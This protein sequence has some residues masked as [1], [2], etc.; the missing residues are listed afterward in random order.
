MAKGDK[1]ELVKERA[2]RERKPARLF[3]QTPE[4]NNR[5]QSSNRRATTGADD[6]KARRLPTELKHK[7]QSTKKPWSEE[8]DR[9]V[10]R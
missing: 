1:D 9:L 2:A 8:E 4:T 5:P 3:M 10:T 6:K 7:G